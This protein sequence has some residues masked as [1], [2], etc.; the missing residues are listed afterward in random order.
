MASPR[1]IKK[2]EQGSSDIPLDEEGIAMTKRLAD[3]L[4]GEQWDVISTSPL[5]RA[6][7]TAE[8]IAERMPNL[9]LYP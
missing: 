3:R 5:L 1:G 8:I 7:E 4:S 9:P 2:R 6:K